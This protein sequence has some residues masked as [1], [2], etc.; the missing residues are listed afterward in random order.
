MPECRTVRHPVSPVPDW[1]KLTMPEQVRYRTKLT[2]SG[3]FL[4]R[5]RTKIQDAGMPMPAL[6]SSMP[7]PSYG[8]LAPG[9][10]PSTTDF[11]KI[12][13]YL[14]DRETP[15]YF[16]TTRLGRAAW[17]LTR[18]CSAGRR[19][20]LPTPTT[21]SKAPHV[22]SITS[23]TYL[24]NRTSE[25]PQFL[26]LNECYGTEFSMTSVDRVLLVFIWFSFCGIS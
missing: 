10:N 14:Y 3:I 6:V 5:Y 13:T 2:Q 18:L 15:L 7:M 23:H 9:G 8:H 4:V 25:C 17:S 21:S 26:H 11:P 20:S 1:K 16:S 19:S 22:A 12:V 24:I